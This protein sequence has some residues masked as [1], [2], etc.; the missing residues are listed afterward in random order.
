M[1]NFDK[2]IQQKVEQFDVPFND[3]HWA[4]ME[5]R[6]NQV[7]SNRIKNVLFGSAAAIITLAISSYFILPF[8]SVNDLNSN[9]AIPAEKINKKS[10]AA[11]NN[12]IVTATDNKTNN[13]NIIEEK[14]TIETPLP[15]S[16]TNSAKEEIVQPKTTIAQ[17][18]L[19]A[20]T[21]TLEESEASTPKVIT[22]ENTVI[23]Q[24]KT[25][26]TQPIV[27]PIEEA[28][29]KEKDTPNSIQATKT[30]ETKEI[31]A[32][33]PDKI[34]NVR[35]KVYEDEL[36]TKKSIKR[37]RRGILSFISFRKK[38]YKVPLS[39]KKSSNRKK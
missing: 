38:I 2:I 18:R 16:F 37:R 34:K 15:V 3:A 23:L 14:A 31:P 10:S 1:D 39:R 29:I 28:L 9:T 24:E 11:T 6:L 20:P 22:I 36:V 12:S 13:E 7:R 8:N 17:E 32:V 5:G 30:V 35:H 27:A 26:I 25:E 33:S 21:S 4:E 19:I